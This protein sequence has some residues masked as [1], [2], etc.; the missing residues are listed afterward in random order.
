MASGKKGNKDCKPPDF[1]PL[2]ND[3]LAPSGL[4]ACSCLDC[5]KQ[6]GSARAC[7]GTAHAKEEHVKVDTRRSEEAAAMRRAEEAVQAKKRCLI[8]GAGSSGV[9]A[10]QQALAAGLEPVAYEAR[11][12]IGGAWRFDAD[13]GSCE[14][15]F[16]EQGWARLSSPSERNH[17]GV[18][19]PSPMYSSLRT[20]VP[21]TLMQYRGSPFP[22][23]VGLFCSHSDVQSYLE[24]FS[25]PLLPHIRFNSRVTRLRHSLPS[26]EGGQQRRWYAEI[27][28]KGKVEKEQFDCVMISN[29]HYSVPYV[30][31]VEG[32]SSWKGELSHARWY[33]DAK[34]FENKTVLVIGN[35]ASGYDVTRELA[36][37]IHS[38]RESGTDPTALP[39]IYQSAR[40]PPVLGIPFDAADAPEWAKEIAVFPPVRKV[41][42][43]VIE[44]EDSRTLEDVDTIIYC[45]GYYY[46]FP[47][48]YPTDA[49]FSEH[50]LTRPPPTPS[51]LTN[52]KL[53]PAPVRGG[54]R[55]H[56]LDDRFLFYLPDP[57]LAFLCL[58]Y[59]VIP[60]PLAQLQ[61]RLA[62]LHFASSPRLPR[63]LTFT[64]GTPE[65]EPESRAPVVL[66]HPKQYDL[67]DRMLRECGDIPEH[68]EEGEREGER[69][70]VT[71]GAEEAPEEE[72]ATDAF[73]GERT[74][75][76][77]TSQAERDLRL[78]AKALRRAVLGY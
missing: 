17:Q 30:P 11:A 45:T 66:G 24:S 37:S 2:G 75:Y 29:G 4:V 32:L 63:P 28:S 48:C 43:K 39:K 73:G 35:S 58:P 12:G 33:R 13:P 19:P 16:D 10:I 68:E 56:N 65:D 77:E 38:R 23:K 22:R 55:V 26:D 49:P 52:T 67:H 3:D 57:S 21:T 71:N 42:G 70:A 60:F 31:W 36:M 47:F 53:P 41:E 64:R 50:P 25:A 6:A 34:A 78:G 15:E 8:I 62:A 61:A 20:N 72:N 5:R 27:A 1:D 7:A 51:N 14:V 46:S 18:P 40:S 59:L 9:A 44:F 69:A 54:L 74:V 76:G